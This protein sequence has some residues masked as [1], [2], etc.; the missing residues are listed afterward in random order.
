MDK[1]GYVLLRQL[2]ADVEG[3]PYPNSIDSE[4]YTIWYEHVRR[5]TQDALEYLATS[6]PGIGDDTIDADL[7]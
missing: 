4:L 5:D 2:I 7:F 6:D 3:A 1:K